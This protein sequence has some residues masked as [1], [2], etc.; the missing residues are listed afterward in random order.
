EDKAD[1]QGSADED[2][3]RLLNDFSV[4]FE[5]AMN[6]DFDTPVV[7]A[8]FQRLRS[9]LN[10]RMQGLG[11][12]TRTHVRETFRRFGEVL[13][14]FQV[15][16]KEWEFSVPTGWMGKGA[17]TGFPMQPKG[18]HPAYGDTITEPPLPLIEE[19]REIQRKVDERK[20]A[21]Q[22]KD[23]RRANEIKKELWERYRVILED[24]P[25]G[26]TRW[27]R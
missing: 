18:G 1:S 9:E 27:K 8:D 19:E 23:F 4:V 15:P 13:G 5:R 26:T 20:E 24:R 12:E 16:V 6:D 22:R 7:I 10:S 14:L 2:A 3:K 17:Q 11:Q 21:R 25:D